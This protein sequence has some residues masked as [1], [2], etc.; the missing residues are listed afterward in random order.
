VKHAFID[1]HSLDDSTVHRLHP[2]TKAALAALVL[3]AALAIPFPRFGPLLPL[4][5]L[6]LLGAALSRVS[7]IHLAGKMKIPLA[8]TVMAVVFMPFLRPA[9]AR[10][11][12]ATWPVIIPLYPESAFRALHVTAGAAVA[13]AAMILLLATTPFQDLLRVLERARVPG[14]LLRILAVFYRYLFILTDEA[15]KMELAI[16]ARGAGAF[17]RGRQLRMAG[18]LAGVLFLRSLERGEQVY[19]SMCARGFEGRFPSLAA[20][21]FGT[22]DALALGLGLAAAGFSLWRM[23]SP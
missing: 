8:L 16:A 5:A 15:E 23:L 19:L 1:H 12:L 10:I 18:N 22:A 4:V 11:V 20:P 13:I 2:A 6:L 9:P 17:H 21:R 7:L 3:A 14:L